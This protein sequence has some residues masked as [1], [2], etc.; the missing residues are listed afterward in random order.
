M[1]PEQTD[2]LDVVDEAAQDGV[3]GA[4]ALLK[5][6]AARPSVCEEAKVRYAVYLRKKERTAEELALWREIAR[7]WPDNPHYAAT[8]KDLE[9]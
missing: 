7:R 2:A 8:L 4:E 5:A 6:Q 3:D 1:Q 9:K